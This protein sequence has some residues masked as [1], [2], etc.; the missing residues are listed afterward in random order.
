MRECPNLGESLAAP[1]LLLQSRSYTGSQAILKRVVAYGGCARGLARSCN[2]CLT[3]RVPVRSHAL[4][5]QACNGNGPPIVLAFIHR[6]SSA[7]LNWFIYVAV[8]SG[9]QDGSRDLSGGPLT[10]M[11]DRLGLRTRNMAK[12][13]RVT[14]RTD[15]VVPFRSSGRLGS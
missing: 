13:K 3:H 8:A 4:L 1:V 14:H 5:R 6:P 2:E 15:L 10:S 12:P 7:S 9:L 11:E